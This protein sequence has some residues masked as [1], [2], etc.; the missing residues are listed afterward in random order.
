MQ[1]SLPQEV[2]LPVSLYQSLQGKYFVGYADNLT[3][4][5][6][7]NAWAGLFNPEGSGAL[8]FANV[9]TIT[10]VQGEPFAAEI[11]FNAD[12]PG[13]PIRADLVTPAN[14]AINPPPV[15]KVEILEASNVPIVPPSGGI[16]VYAQQVFAESTI[17]FEVNGKYI[18]PPGGSVA[19]YLNVIGSETV[20]RVAFGWWEEPLADACAVCHLGSG[21]RN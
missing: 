11:W 10:N 6:E 14:T 15:P 20:G 4:A 16:K 2:V 19:V 9:I 13:S 3:A 1:Q 7:A 8:L 18:A 5:P 21:R 17:V 12:F